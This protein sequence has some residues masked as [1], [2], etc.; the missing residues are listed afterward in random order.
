M[1]TFEETAMREAVE[2]VRQGMRLREAAKAKAVAHQTLARYVKK[3]EQHPGQEIRMRPTYECRMVFD[4][5]QEKALADYLVASSNMFYGIT[6]KECRRL[7]YEMCVVSSIA[8]PTK[9]ADEMAAGIDWYN[10]FMKRHPRLSLRTPE[11]CSLARATSLNHHNVM[12]FY[13]NLEI[14][15][16]RETKFG[17]GT[18][19]FN[20][21]E[22]GIT[23]VH[24][25]PKV[26]AEK[27]VKQVSK[28]TSGEEGTLTTTCCIINAAGNSLPPAMIFP[29]VNFRE[30]MLRGAPPGTLG[31]ANKSGWMNSELFSEVIDHFIHHSTSSKDQPSLL[32]YDNHESHLSIEVLDKAN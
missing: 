10:G 32:M 5:E 15:M 22:T 6:T 2:L 14:I 20:L 3:Q 26:I 24:I 1:G 13:N 27:G 7:A 19:I 18:R 4:A 29:R 8:C 16:Q 31:L 9:W 23:T 17:D 11:G 28:C 30:H 12:Q 25:P 21:D